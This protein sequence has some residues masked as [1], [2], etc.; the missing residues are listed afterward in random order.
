VGK[1]R[2]KSSIREVITVGEGKETKAT[3]SRSQGGGRE[4]D[5]SKKKQM[6]MVGKGKEVKAAR[7]R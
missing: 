2:C 7:G 4:G 5:E 1:E 6:T 3:R